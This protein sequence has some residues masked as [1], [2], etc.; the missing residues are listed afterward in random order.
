[1]KIIRYRY[2]PLTAYLLYA[3]FVIGCL[4]FG[5]VQFEGIGYG[6]LLAFLGAY[7]FLFAIGYLVGAKGAFSVPVERREAMGK[8]GYRRIRKI[9][10]FLLIVAVAQ[11]VLGWADLII[12]GGASNFSAL[13]ERYSDYYG[14]YERGQAKVDLQYVAS[15]L[16]QAALALAI[17]LGLA[18][19]RHLEKGRRWLLVFVVGSYVLVNLLGSGKQKYLGDIVIFVLV[20]TM[21][22]MA[23]RGA[24]L[25]PARMAKLAAFSAV[26]LLIFA[27]ILRQR[28][29]YIGVGID[30]IAEMSHPLVIW[31]VNT[32]LVELFGPDYGFAFG[33]VLFYFSNGLYGLYLCLTLP[34]EWT[35]LVGSSYS[36][37][38]VAEIVTGEPGAILHSTYPYRAGLIY[39]WGLEKWHSA[40]S[41][42]ASDIGF[43]G[44][45][46]LTPAFGLFYARLWR[47][48]VN[49]LNVAA[50]PLFIYLSL[51]LAF[52]FA[53]NQL[54]HAMS[55]VIVLGVLLILRKLDQRWQRRRLIGAGQHRNE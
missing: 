32:P 36:I 35:Y 52:S 41:W 7:L 21:I 13:G 16:V 37:G 46:V 22:G 38:R 20:A 39:G 23:A 1:M 45:L 54:V 25:R 24:K 34:F 10:G 31:D 40:F 5:P 30:S 29:S 33:Y 12:S 9:F 28:Y 42:I 15:I 2:L 17:I 53:N 50:A 8:D 48:A 47:E 14:G 18:N 11:S 49:S 51:G 43:T 44:V 26:S 19:Y 4:L 27:E 6:I 55:G 3:A